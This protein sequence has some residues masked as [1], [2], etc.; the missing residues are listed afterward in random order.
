[1]GILSALAMQDEELGL[2][3]EQQIGMH[4]T[5]NCYP[6]VPAS[7]I[8]P[9]IKALDL[10]NEGKGSV[11]VRLPEGITFRGYPIAPAYAIVEQHRLEAWVVE[12]WLY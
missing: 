8:E 4:F 5:S 3:L 1:M 10:V 6:Q 11:M 2:T 9:A 7:M 12:K